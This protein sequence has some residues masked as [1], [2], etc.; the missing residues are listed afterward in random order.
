LNK[1]NLK[2]PPRRFGERRTGKEMTNKSKP[3]A[4]AMSDDEFD[5]RFPYEKAAIDWFIDVRY[6]DKLVC[7]HCG[8]R[9]SIYRERERLKVFHCSECNN[10][11][12]PIKGTI[13]E[14]T[15]IEIRKWFKVIGVRSSCCK[16]SSTS[17]LHFFFQSGSSAW[18]LFISSN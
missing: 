7:P 12:S 16:F 14:K 10:S 2:L 13:F 18:A 5:S 4:R 6:K 17:I 15:H 9:V 3:A 11:F 1:S 8:T